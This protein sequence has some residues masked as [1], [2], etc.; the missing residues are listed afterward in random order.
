MQ[1]TAR[2]AGCAGLLGLLA[3]WARALPS[4]ELLLAQPSWQLPAAAASDQ[5]ISYTCWQVIAAF[6]HLVDYQMD[7]TNNPSNVSC[8]TPARQRLDLMPYSFAVTKLMIQTACFSSDGS[9]V[10]CH[11]CYQYKHPSLRCAEYC[12]TFC[13]A[14][15]HAFSTCKLTIKLNAQGHFLYCGI[16]H[17]ASSCSLYHQT[18]LYHYGQLPSPPNSHENLMAPCAWHMQI[19]DMTLPCMLTR[20]YTQ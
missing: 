6:M 14:P 5:Q 19:A 9:I 20:Q 3:R 11:V 16:Q 7:Y 2:A 1:G 17:C 12:Q 10:S 8:C 13:L 18:L 4:L 15:V